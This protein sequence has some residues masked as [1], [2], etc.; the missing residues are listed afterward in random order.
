MFYENVSEKIL[1]LSKIMSVLR[2]VNRL[3]LY[4]LDF[5]FSNVTIDICLLYKIIGNNIQHKIIQTQNDFHY[6][7]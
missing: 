5:F 2:N 1:L 7:Q 6:I 4:V 3:T